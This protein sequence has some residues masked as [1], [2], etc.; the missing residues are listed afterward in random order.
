MKKKQI[1][2]CS[3]KVSHVTLLMFFPGSLLK[4]QMLLLHSNNAFHVPYD[5]LSVYECWA[6]YGKMVKGCLWLH[7][8]R[9][10]LKHK[11][12]KNSIWLVAGICFIIPKKSNETDF[13]LR[14]SSFLLISFLG[15]TLHNIPQT[16]VCDVL[17]FNIGSGR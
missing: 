12:G 3:G 4:R 7:V 8:F 6:R 14:L 2:R 15:S 13:V 10:K 17:P 16:S 9:Q 5:R 1:F 11:W